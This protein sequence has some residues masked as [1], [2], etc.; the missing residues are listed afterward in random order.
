MSYDAIPS[1]GIFLNSYFSLITYNSV[2]VIGLRLSKQLR[3]DFVL[4]FS[5]FDTEPM[6]DSIT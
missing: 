2:L 4:V 1:S 5:S 3:N 6:L